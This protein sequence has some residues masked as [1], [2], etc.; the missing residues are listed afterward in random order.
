[1]GNFS[2]E[3]TRFCAT[4]A[5]CAKFKRFQQSD[6]LLI[7]RENIWD[8]RKM[9]L[10]N[11]MLLR[12]FH[13]IQCPVLEQPAKFQ[14]FQQS[15]TI[16]IVRENLDVREILARNQQAFVRFEVWNTLFGCPGRLRASL[17]YPNLPQLKKS[18]RVFACICTCP[19]FLA[20]ASA[21]GI[22]IEEQS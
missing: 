10:R 19:K 22:L 4:F 15:D 14:R 8:Q 11:R 5:Q 6:T 9:L 12:D 17:A 21:L 13:E 7:R 16:R 1:M 20:L 18:A 2:L 3:I